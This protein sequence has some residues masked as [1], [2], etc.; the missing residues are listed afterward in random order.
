LAFIVQSVSDTFNGPYGNY[1]MTVDEL[2]VFKYKIALVILIIFAPLTWVRDLERFRFGLIF[3]V[4]MIFV[5][6][7]VITIFDIS[8]ISERN[9]TEPTSGYYAIND[10]RYFDMIGFCFF[11]FEG[12]AMVMPI[13]N[14]C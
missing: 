12:I 2:H 13:M 10:E 3:A 1:K 14:A 4:M 7:L 11:M 8:E 5:V 6:C 9:G